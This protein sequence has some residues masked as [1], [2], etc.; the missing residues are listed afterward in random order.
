ME[1]DLKVREVSIQVGYQSAHSFTRFFKKMTGFTPKEYRENLQQ[2][3]S[4]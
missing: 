3:S 1:G 4:S 2:A